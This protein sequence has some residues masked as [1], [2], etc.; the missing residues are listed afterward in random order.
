MVNF[1]LYSVGAI[2]YKP[3]EDRFHFR[4]GIE[5]KG[6]TEYGFFNCF[7]DNFDDAERSINIVVVESN[8][9]GKLY[10]VFAETIEVHTSPS[11]SSP[12]I[13]ALALM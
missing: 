4:V 5:N 9:G 11:F 7:H 12:M 10:N 1:D 2:V 3:A 8:A 13:E 6:V